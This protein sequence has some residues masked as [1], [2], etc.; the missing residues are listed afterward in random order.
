MGTPQL[1]ENLSSQGHGNHRGE[2]GLLFFRR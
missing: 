2:F 1:A